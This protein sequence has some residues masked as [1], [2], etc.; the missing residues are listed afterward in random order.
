LDAFDALLE[1]VARH[2]FGRI[3]FKL[4]GPRAPHSFVELSGGT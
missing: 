3:R 4:T 1:E 2:Q